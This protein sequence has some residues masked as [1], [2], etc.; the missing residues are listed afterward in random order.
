MPRREDNAASTRSAPSLEASRRYSGEGFL[1]KASRRLRLSESSTSLPVRSVDSELS[2]QPAVSPYCLSN[3]S[4]HS[5]SDQS[6]Q[7]RRRR[8][9][10]SG[11]SS[12]AGNERTGSAAS[13]QDADGGRSYPPSAPSAVF[14]ERRRGTSISSR[15]SASQPVSP[16]LKQ[17]D[18]AGSVSPP[19]RLQSLP[20]SAWNGQ[21]LMDETM[22]ERPL[23]RMSSTR[24]P[25]T[26]EGSSSEQMSLSTSGQ[27]SCSTVDLEA[28]PPAFI[29][30]MLERLGLPPAGLDA[31][32]LDAR[33]DLVCA[34][35]LDPDALAN[36]GPS[37]A[38]EGSAAEA[39]RR[40]MSFRR[41]PRRLSEVSTTSRR[42]PLQSSVR[43]V[44]RLETE[45]LNHVS[46]C[47]GRKAAD[48]EHFSQLRLAEVFQRAR[49]HLGLDG[50][51]QFTLFTTSGTEPCTPMPDTR[52]SMESTRPELLDT[53]SLVAAPGSMP[54]S[55]PPRRRR[56]RP[57]TAPDGALAQDRAGLPRDSGAEAA[58]RRGHFVPTREASLRFSA[59]S[60]PGTLPP[61][62]FGRQPWVPPS[63]SGW[64]VDSPGSPTPSRSGHAPPVSILC[65]PS[66]PSGHAAPAIPSQ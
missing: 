58:R 40:R 9:L 21:A 30:P 7:S 29:A 41:R 43:E 16:L 44:E 34:W 64:T 51:S 37:A 48:K 61:A 59:A 38:G 39:P 20:P 32:D 31:H 56:R 14:A 4:A 42:G 2:A 15:H 49:V 54:L 11:K 13:G 23:S 36:T 47:L 45:M 5:L 55:P 3:G 63:T 62:A 10:P 33:V 66:A 24:R 46:R 1:A 17:R 52:T 28:P 26:T 60:P 12:S 50:D 65:N 53:V 57:Q 25:S 6:Q 8:R 27:T 22:R 18:F 19:P 35:V